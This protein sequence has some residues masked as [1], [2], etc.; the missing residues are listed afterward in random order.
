MCPC[1]LVRDAVCVLLYVSLFRLR[2]G[3][4]N[5]L[6]CSIDEDIWC[7]HMGVSRFGASILQQRVDVSIILH[8]VLVSL[9]MLLADL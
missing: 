1:V 3:M 4:Y 9:F 6:L 8:I 2:V 5:E 7:F